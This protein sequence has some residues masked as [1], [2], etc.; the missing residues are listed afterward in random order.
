MLSSC[1]DIF[2]TEHIEVCESK[3][4][5]VGRLQAVCDALIFPYAENVINDKEFALLHD[6]N[7]SKP[8][9]PYWKFEDFD[10]G[11]WDKVECRT[12]LWFDNGLPL[13]LRCLQI[14]KQVVCEQGTVCSGMEGL[15]TVLK[16]LAYSCRYTDMAH[17]FGR[18]PSE[19]CHL[20]QSDGQYL[21]DTIIA[22][23]IGT[24]L[25]FP[26]INSTTMPWQYT[27]VLL[28]CK[29]VFGL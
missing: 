15:C 11:T 25:F 26:Q 23:K 7:R 21:R 28:L 22:L 4:M 3:V 8:L 14:P 1:H 24:S 12:G 19:L 18:N 10:L 17:R 2:Y 9:F 27:N 29:I 13:L 5:A 20:Q 6:Y 16:R